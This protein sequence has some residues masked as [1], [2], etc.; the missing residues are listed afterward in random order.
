MDS[1]RK[2]LFIVNAIFRS[3]LKIKLVL[4][5]SLLA[6]SYLCSVKGEAK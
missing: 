4:F 3:K 5:G 1:F 6:Y 2:K